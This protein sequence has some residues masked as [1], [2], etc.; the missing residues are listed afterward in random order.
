MDSSTDWL[1]FTQDEMPVLEENGWKIEK[2]T[3]YRYDL[4]NIEKWYASIT[5]NDEDLD[6]DWFNL[7]LGIVV[8][9]KH[10]SVFPLLLP[11][12]QKYPDT[13]DYKKLDEQPDTDSVLATLP[14]NNR[15]WLSLEK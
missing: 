9:H 3:D 8:N 4:Q 1:H 14:N 12:I 15:D 10:F 5:E 11:L 2:S 13:F 7:E 6:R